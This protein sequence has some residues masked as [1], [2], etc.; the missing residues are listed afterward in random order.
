MAYGTNDRKA[1][2]VRRGVTQRDI[3]EAVGCSEVQVHKVIVGKRAEGP[4]AQ[5]VMRHIAELLGMAVEDVFPVEA[6][7]VYRWKEEAI[8]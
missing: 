2:L 1:E 6:E 7:T 5:K 4:A 8:A 3:A